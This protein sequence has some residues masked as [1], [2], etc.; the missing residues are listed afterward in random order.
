MPKPDLLLVSGLTARIVE[1]LERDFTIHRYCDADD[2]PAFLAALPE[3]VRFVATGGS[4]G[5]SREIIEALPDLEISP[6]W[7]ATWTGWS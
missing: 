6:R 4:A 7:P 5:C 3:G 2:K 1:Q